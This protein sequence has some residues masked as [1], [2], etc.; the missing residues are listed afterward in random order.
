[1]TQSVTFH[2][3][4]SQFVIKSGVAAFTKGARLFSDDEFRVGTIQ[5]GFVE[6]VLVEGP[7]EF[8]AILGNLAVVWSENR[9]LYHVGFLNVT[10]SLQPDQLA[11]RRIVVRLVLPVILIVKVE[12]QAGYRVPNIAVSLG[13]PDFGATIEAKTDSRGEIVLLAHAGNYSMKITNGRDRPLQ[14]NVAAD[15][16]LTPEDSGERVVTLRTE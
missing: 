14:T 11:S 15:V 7:I 3:I 10:G 5:D 8:D 1:M 16:T 9:R 13:L 4:S 6:D 12:N 2:F